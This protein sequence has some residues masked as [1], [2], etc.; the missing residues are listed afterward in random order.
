MGEKLG[1]DPHIA[2]LRHEETEAFTRKIELMATPALFFKEDGAVHVDEY[3]EQTER[4]VR[5]GFIDLVYLLDL[6][7][8]EFEDFLFR[9]ALGHQPSGRL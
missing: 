7:V 5:D 9:C 1:S 4:E 6:V 8:Q 2:E 3:D